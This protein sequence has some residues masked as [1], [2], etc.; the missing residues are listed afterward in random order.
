M[1]RAPVLSALLFLLPLSAVARDEVLTVE[2]SA[3]GE[4]KEAFLVR[5]GRYMQ[6]WTNRNDVEACGLIAES[7]GRYAVAVNTQRM[8]DQCLTGFVLPGW[9]H[10][11]ENIHSHPRERLARGFRRSTQAHF[12]DVDYLSPGYLVANGHLFYQNGVGTD[13][14]VSSL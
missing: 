4:S 12:S 3:Q 11:G 8:R 6:G 2:V 14:V 13:R 7:E 5:V 10:T 1:K 9:K